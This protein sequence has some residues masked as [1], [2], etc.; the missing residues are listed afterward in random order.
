[1]CQVRHHFFDGGHQSLTA[2]MRNPAKPMRHNSNM[3]IDVYCFSL[4]VY[5]VS[6]GRSN[7]SAR[8][9]SI[10]PYTYT[11]SHGST[12]PRSAVD[13]KTG[14]SITESDQSDKPAMLWTSTRPN[15]R[16]RQRHDGS[17]ESSTLPS[18][19]YLF[20]LHICALDYTPISKTAGFTVYE[21]ALQ[22]WNGKHVT[23]LQL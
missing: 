14:C 7:S 6:C 22:E 13:F 4:F 8:P 3:H 10:I 16:P 23:S 1:M 19:M 11:C 9:S 21:I 12:L 20:S 2:G 18:I 17:Y 5:K 15:A